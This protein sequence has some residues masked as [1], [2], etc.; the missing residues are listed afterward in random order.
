VVHDATAVYVAV[1]VSDDQVVNDSAESGTEDGTTWEDDSVEIFFD[2]NNDKQLA[3]GAEEF[4]GQ[5]VLTA[6]GAWRDHEA[7]NPLFGAE[8]DWFAATSKTAK[9]YQIEFKVNK[10]ALLN[11]ADGAVLGFHIAQNDDD[12]AGRRAQLGWSGR[13][14]SEFT[15]GSLTLAGGGSPTTPTFRISRNGQQLTL[16]WTGPGTLQRAENIQG[17]WTAVTGASSPFQAEATGTAGYYRIR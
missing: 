16:T 17:P 1:D 9:G 7:N 5:Y 4:E 11:P 14:H 12:G 2:A 8:N 13:A 10:S 6:N 15:Y 3:R